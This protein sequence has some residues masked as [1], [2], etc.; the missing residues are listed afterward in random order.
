MLDGVVLGT[1][2]GIVGDGDFEAVGIAE[3]MLQGVLPGAG[4]AAV[5]AAAVGEDSELG[6]V[7]IAALTGGSPPVVETVDRE[8]RRVVGVADDDGAV[9]GE[10]VVDAVGNGEAVG[11]GAEVVVEDL[12]GL[13]F[14]G[15]AGVL[16]VADEF[17]LLGVDADQG[18]VLGG[19]TTLEGG[20][21][22]KLGVAVGRGD[23]GELLAIDAQG[24]AGGG[25]QAG[26]GAGGEGEAEGGRG[27]GRA[28]RWCGESSAGRSKGLRRCR[29]P[30]GRRGQRSVQGFFFEGLAAA[31]RSADL[32]ARKQDGLVEQF[33]AAAGDGGG[34]Q[35][36]QD[37]RAAVAALSAFQRG[38]SAVEAALALV[39]AGRGSAGGPCRDRHGA[40]CPG[41]AG[42]SIPRRAWPAAGVDGGRVRERSRGS[43]RRP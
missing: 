2:G 24:E 33:S 7:G 20:D 8:E 6:G 43:G 9:V 4:V 1:A 3:G 18:A 10:Q 13:L 39:R 40:G 25:E 29:V 31:A 30:A 37:G 21:E 15:G 16:E 5:A 36:G 42:R 17:L 35:A 23:G 19:A 26:D 32:P 11:E 12:D 41:A 38:E 14:P 34:M 27:R 28:W 22:L